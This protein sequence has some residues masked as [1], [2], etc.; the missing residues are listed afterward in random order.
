MQMAWREGKGICVHRSQVSAQ[1]ACTDKSI[2]YQGRAGPLGAC[3]PSIP[4]LLDTLS[5]AITAKYSVTWHIPACGLEP[6]S[7]SHWQRKGRATQLLKMAVSAFLPQRVRTDIPAI[8][9][10]D[11]AQLH[12]VAAAP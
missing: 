11:P 6:P 2:H 4:W 5:A 12:F 1:L 3:S 8:V 10:E 9:E 7:P